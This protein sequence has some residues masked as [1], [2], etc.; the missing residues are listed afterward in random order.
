[1]SSSPPDPLGAVHVP[2]RHNHSAGDRRRE[3]HCANCRLAGDES[4]LFVL[5]AS[6]LRRNV[7]RLVNTGDANLDDACA[8]AWAHLLTGQPR[9]DTVLPWL[10]KVAMREAIRLD[11]RDRR[12]APIDSELIAHN[13]STEGIACDRMILLETAE[14]LTAIHPRRRR[15]PLMHAVGIPCDEIAATYRITPTRVRA[16]IYKAR[17][18]LRE[19]VE[20]PPPGD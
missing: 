9:R 4:R 11:G 13:S 10:V 20:D 16:L 2:P 3:T 18:Q 1:L 19:I 17:L 15:M 6:R 5:Y 12:T 14:A 8:F 7:G